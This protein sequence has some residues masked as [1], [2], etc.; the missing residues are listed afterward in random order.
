MTVAFGQLKKTAA[1]ARTTSGSVD[2]TVSK[3]IQ[4]QPPRGR[5]LRDPVIHFLSHL[6]NALRLTALDKLLV[7]PNTPDAMTVAGAVA[8][9]IRLNLLC[10]SA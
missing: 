2:N 8:G 1:M 3:T 10:V 6:A 5:D 4:F 7:G 9:V